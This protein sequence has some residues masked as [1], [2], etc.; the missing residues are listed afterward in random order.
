M[1]LLAAASVLAV[2]KG[3]MTTYWLLGRA[4]CPG[5][6]MQMCDTPEGQP[7]EDL[8]AEIPGEILP[9]DFCGAGD[10]NDGAASRSV[11]IPPITVRQ[12]SVSSL[13]L[14]L[15]PKTTVEVA[16]KNEHSRRASDHT[17]KQ[18]TQPSMKDWR[19]S[20][21]HHQQDSERV[22]LKLASPVV[23]SLPMHSEEVE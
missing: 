9:Y 23:R 2:S 11:M 14:T 7:T 8:A 15:D 5:N 1:E 19:G 3:K 4:D 17:Y 22:A 16:A 6:I 20:S 21:G 13:S 10:P 18:G 12:G